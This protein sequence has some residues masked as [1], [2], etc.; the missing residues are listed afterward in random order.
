M[1]LFDTYG[2]AVGGWSVFKI[3][4]AYSG[5][6][7]RVRRSV[8]SPPEQDIG[9][10]VAG[11]NYYLDVAA[12]ATFCAGTDGYVTTVY[13][14]GTGSNATQ[15]TEANQP[16]ICLNG[17]V[18]VRGAFAGFGNF[19]ASSSQYLNYTAIDMGG[20][21]NTLSV[22][23][24]VFANGSAV[25]NPLPIVSGGNV[26][27]AI[28]LETSTSNT[29]SLYVAQ[30]G[31]LDYFNSS[32]FTS[33]K[34]TQLSVIQNGSG[35]NG[36]VDGSLV[37]TTASSNASFGTNSIGYESL[38]G[39]YYNDVIFEVVIYDTDKSSDRAA[40]DA[41]QI[42]RFTAATDANLTASQT[43]AGVT[44]TA[45]V[46][47]RDSATASQTLAGV[48][49]T[50]IIDTEIGF[51]T[52]QTLQP[53]TQ[54]AGDINVT[55]TASQTLE[56]V[57]Q[58]SIVTTG[59]ILPNYKP[60]L[61]VDEVIDAL[62][63]FVLPFMR[64][65]KVVRAQTNRV[66]FPNAPCATLKEILQVD[67]DTPYLTYNP[68][69]GVSVINGP[70]RIDIQIDFY[71]LIAGELCMA[72]KAAFRTV[73]ASDQFP[74]NIK[75]LYTSDG[76][77]SPLTTG[78]QQY[79]SRWTLTASMQYNPIITVPQQFADVAQVFKTDPVDVFE[80]L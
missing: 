38:F 59:E 77:Q 9:F 24:V 23:G 47:P 65:G 41:D 67:I 4:N 36:Y 17:V 66:T 19:I 61:S 27:L 48:T 30:S 55:L 8:G 14:Q 79:E 62:Q 6:C 71:G 74:L 5:S 80:V 44:Q 60:S 15:T 21:L 57:S 7:I 52:N 37:G 72:V 16:R 35:V 76:L 40:I 33:N 46:R 18:D 39:N 32:T 58:V 50:T 34:I 1:A 73:W 53:V 10:V 49:Q 3:L 12:I 29:T 11:A 20:G 64:G 25:G 43:L 75:P 42:A 22:F 54:V 63:A 31:Q 13:N 68:N 45:T 56:P 69:V 51:S 70:Q 26:T 78:E 28:R 2:V